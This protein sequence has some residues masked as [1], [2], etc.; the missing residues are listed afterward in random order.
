MRKLDVL[1]NKLQNKEKQGMY[2]YFYN[3]LFA[4]VTSELNGVV[5]GDFCRGCKYFEQ[6]VSCPTPC[7]G[8]KE[9]IKDF[10]DL[11]QK[12]DWENRQLEILDYF[13]RGYVRQEE[14]LK[15][16]KEIAET[17]PAIETEL[18][19]RILEVIKESEV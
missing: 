5:N 18:S 2:L 9:F 10:D 6:E 17:A 7:I 11:L 8:F 3:E 19:Q 13:C 15:K 16:I 4:K 14:A 1:L 12:E